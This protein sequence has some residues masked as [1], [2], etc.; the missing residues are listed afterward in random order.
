MSFS[1]MMAVMV[2]LKALAAIVLSIGFL[3]A[4]VPT[5][6]QEVAPEHLALAREYV[7]LTD[8]AAIYETTLVQTAIDT[9]R[10]IVS[11]NPELT[12]VTNTAITK[13]LDQYKGHKGDLL[14]QFARVYAIR[15][16]MDE[17][18]EIVAFYK[19]P[20]GSK[21]AQANL[22]LN[23]DMQN[24]LKIFTANLNQEFFAKVRAEL[25]ANG[26]AF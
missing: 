3:A 7:D 17:L 19:S 9:M 23:T 2:R 6:A 25:K 8:R 15:F 14:D 5:M 4:A 22:E 16:S 1:T 21:L 18:K 20:T 10:Q 11:Q 13:I 24:V 12:D 26:V